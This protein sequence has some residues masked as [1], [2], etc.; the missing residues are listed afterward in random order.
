VLLNKIDAI[1]IV[2]FHG[3]L[4]AAGARMHGSQCLPQCKAE[5]ANETQ[6]LRGQPSRADRRTGAYGF[7]SMYGTAEQCARCLAL[8]RQRLSEQQ[9]SCRA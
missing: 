7:K 4:T 2:V 8:A 6:W 3:Q 9:W 5:Q 1:V